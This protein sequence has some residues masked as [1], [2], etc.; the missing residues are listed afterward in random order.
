M[1]SGGKDPAIICAD[2]DIPSV[3]AQVCT[4]ALLNSGQICLAVK[5]IYIHSSIYAEFREAMVTHIKTLKTG[6]GFAADTFLGP[7]Q[8][9]M[10][11][12]KV[13]NLFDDIEKEGWKVAVGGSIDTSATGYYITPTVID[14]PKDDSRIVV[15]EPFGPILPILSWENEDEVV[16]RANNTDLGL[17]ASVWSRDL[18]QAERI[19]R[20]LESGTAWVNTHFDMSPM[21]P[22]GGV[23]QSGQGVEWGVDGMKAYCNQQTCKFPP[24]NGAVRHVE[25]LIRVQSISRRSEVLQEIV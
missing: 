19:A 17:G 1:S 14:N 23:K 15:E 7:I 5:R 3:A 18:E 4:Y 16:E 11:Y 22:F 10:Q 21:F 6:D 12:N 9:D 25:V 24:S 20:Q 13:K 8:N 2:V